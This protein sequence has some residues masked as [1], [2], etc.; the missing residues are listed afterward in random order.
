MKVR[1]GKKF[2]NSTVNCSV[3]GLAYGQCILNNY[4][5]IRKDD[6][7][8]EFQAFKACVQKNSGKKW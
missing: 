2:L 7:L 4:A 8:K 5:V 3:E 6:C 1:P